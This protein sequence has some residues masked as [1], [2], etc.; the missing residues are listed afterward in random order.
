MKGNSICR[1]GNCQA[2]LFLS[3]ALLLLK[4]LSSQFNRF[5]SPR[6]YSKN[7]ITLLYCPLRFALFCQCGREIQACRHVAW[8][9]CSRF[10]KVTY[11]LVNS[12]FT[13]Q[14]DPDIQVRHSVAGVD[15]QRLFKVN[16]RVVVRVS[17]KKSYAKIRLRKTVI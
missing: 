17:A 12:I 3:L 16:N 2:G 14:Y 11:R 7:L 6:R 15:L 4:N 9:N 1:R 5:A 10:F 13:K 8:V